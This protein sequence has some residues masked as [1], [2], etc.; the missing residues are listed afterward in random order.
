MFPPHDIEHPAGL[1]VGSDMK[2]VKSK[3]AKNRRFFTSQKM[4]QCNDLRIR[5]LIDNLT[6][7]SQ[8]FFTQFDFLKG[9]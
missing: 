9:Q 2:D 3:I 7:D 8:K 1:S 5:R 6:Y 4:L